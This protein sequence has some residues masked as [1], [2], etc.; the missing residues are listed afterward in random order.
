[1]SSANPRKSIDSLASGTSTPSLSH[2]SLEKFD[3]PRVPPQ[4]YP[5]RR[6]SAASS[7]A[8][9]GGILDSSQNHESI[10]EA[11]QNGMLLGWALCV[12]TVNCCSGLVLMSHNSDIHAPSTADCSDGLTTAY[13]C[14]FDWLQTSDGS[15]YPS[16]D[17]AAIAAASA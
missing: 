5:F 3:S 4:R 7:V 17:A 9:I 13:R 2:T 6:G 14:V 10:A 11:G 12:P 16:G 1:M 15:R 8:S